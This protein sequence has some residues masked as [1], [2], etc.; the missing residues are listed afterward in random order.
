MRMTRREFVHRTGLLLA[1]TAPAASAGAPR[2]SAAE[3]V[4]GGGRRFVEPPV[5]S[6]RDGLLD[7]QLT[8]AP[9][10]VDIGPRRVRV[11][12]YEGGLPGPTL[13]VRPGEKL[14]ILLRNEMKALGVPDNGPFPPA[15]SHGPHAG[16][17]GAS[18]MEAQLFTNLHTHG[19]QVSPRDPSDN[20][21][22]TIKPGECHQY[23]YQ[24]P[25]DQPAGL[26]WYHPHFHTS[27]THQAWQGLAGALIVEGDIDEVPEVRE[28]RERLLV[29][30][31]LWVG[32]DGSVPTALVVPNAGFS[33]FTSIPAVPTDIVFPIN[34]VYQPEIDIRPGETQ[35]WRVL[36]AAPHRFF[37]LNVEGHTLHQIGQDGVP[38]A[39]ARPVSRVLIATGNRAEL[40]LKGGPAG[41]YRIWAEAYDQGHPGGPRPRRLLGTL[42]SAGRPTDGPLP[43]RL[44]DPPAMPGPVVA[45]RTLVWSGDISGRNGPGVKFY[46]DGKTFDANRIDQC[47]EAGTVEEWTLVNED[48]FQHPFHIHVNPFRVMDIQGAPADDPTWVYDPT[49]WWD[50]FRLPPRGSIT[51]RIHFRRDVTGLTVFHCHIL[52]HEDNGM[53]GTVCIFPEGKSCS[54]EPGALCAPQTRPNCPPRSAD[55]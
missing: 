14:R 7:T 29:I 24:I 17:G 42:V 8:L 12:A 9:T 2:P 36:G 30:N 40:I 6:S 38:F 45:H 32:E 4:R 31:A 47:V 21:L 18:P 44:V 34:G 53:M 11:E 10:D 19:L 43:G 39:R 52:P 55:G 22:L 28:A 27:T 41:R 13:R 33:P 37:W 26:H 35:R 25:L 15:F 3:S 1:A 23:E 46:I 54:Q 20:V 50:V 51:I 49:I 48:V 5:R 16:H